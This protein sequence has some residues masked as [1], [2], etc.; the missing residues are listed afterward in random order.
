MPLPDHLELLVTDEPTLD[1]WSVGPWRVPDGLCE[2]IGARLDDLV[3]DPRY[4]DLTTDKSSRLKTPAPLVVLDLIVTTEFLLGPS[5][6]RAGSHAFL[7][8]QCY[9]AYYRTGRSSLSTADDWTVGDG[10]FLPLNWLA[11][12]PDLD[13][14]VEL[15]RMS[16]DVLEGVEPL[17][18]RRNA[19]IRLFDDPP[20]LAGL[21]K[22]ARAEA[23]IAR[24]D[25]ETLAALPELAGP[26]GY[27]EWVWSGLRP[28]HEHLVE[29]APHEDSADDLLVRLLAHAGLDDVPPEISAV[30]GEE[31]YRDLLD[32]FAAQRAGHDRDKWVDATGAWLCRTLGAGEAE[33][34]RRW[35]DLVARF[36]GAVNGLPGNALFPNRGPLPTRTVMRQL[37]RLYAPRRSVV[38]PVMSTLRPTTS[39]TAAPDE[40]EQPE[41]EPTFGLV[42]QPD[43]VAALRKMST[44]A[45]DVR[46]LLVGPDG[47]G[48]RD[49]ARQVAELLT[50]RRI[51]GDPLWQAGDHYADKGASSATT[52]VLDAVGDCAGKRVLIIDGLDVLAR[53]D[54]C[55]AAVLEELHR[56]IDVRDDLH[57]VALCEPGGDEAVREVNPA[58]ALRFT[59]VPTH[60]FDADGFA[61]LFRRALRKR[62][63]HAD[64]DALAAAGELLA[65]T[66]PVR[67]LRNARLAPHLAGLVLETVRERTGPGD[68]LAV[69]RADLPESLVDAEK[70]ADPMAELN[71]LTGL[72]A[73][74]QEIELVAA[75]VRAGRLRH[76]AGLPATA[77]PALHMVFTGN[78]GTGKTVVARLVAR[79]FKDLGVLSSGHLVEASRARLVAPYVGQTAPKTRGVVQSALGGVLFIDE[80]YSLTQ[81]ASGNDY[82][83]EAVAELLN[84]LEDHRDDL[85]VI[86]AGYETE[87]QRFLGANPGLASRFP[88]MVR[89]PDYTGAE[90]VEIFTAQASAAGM[91]PSEAA[92]GKVAELLRRAPRV[93]SFGNARVMRNLC[94][95]ATA[96]Q[97]RR[98]TALDTPSADDLTALLPEDIPDVLSGTTRV[99]P[100]T[101]PVAELD[102]LIGLA[103]VKAEV[104]RL[105]AEARAAELRRDAGAKPAAPTRHMVFTG[106]PGTAKTTV[107]RLV[108]AIY[109]KLGLL[110]SGHLVEASRVDL[111]GPYL[112]QTAPRVRAVVERALGGVLFVDEAYALAG[113]AYGQE[114][115]A[116]LIQLMEEYR[117][118]LVVIAA[119]YERE[120]RRFLT[121]NPGLESRFP[122]RVAFPDYTDTELVAIFRHLATAEGFTLAPDV[123]DRLRALLRTSPRGPSF[124]NG[125][126]MRNLL[127]AAIAAQGER[128]TTGDR[129]DDT[130]ITTLRA[131]DLHAVTPE[132]PP[133]RNVGLYL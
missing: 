95:R 74:K 115:I 130:E 48:K 91:E 84:A 64:E 113:D 23:F 63:A 8:R 101:D 108:A 105:V 60:P 109:A 6:I 11:D 72:A 98:V 99:Q 1:L 114:A 94:E 83:A 73:V 123:P 88:T 15:G 69:T 33:A 58:L 36:I 61:E 34:C 124:G 26:T 86:V 37:R 41:Q 120:M 5:A 25:D 47:T 52:K 22:T 35:L 82:G 97:A 125:R 110:S 55:G 77:A 12:A 53:N 131:A 56:A 40:A 14:A 128:I 93:R 45:G 117:G 30:L 79:I 96:L 107:A 104:H 4:A 85:V 111:V 68:E 51:T 133:S 75:R 80:A 81:S 126:L 116:T 17:E 3:A 16:L 59:T 24:A 28:L 100:V 21:T 89:F 71:A 127:D 43:V 129:P 46:L 90:L 13:L 92:L 29:A 10:E 65:R 106:N 87:M 78:P 122:K 132:T 50:D 103:E 31:G 38:N 54:D 67:N 39:T 19:L 102:A 2:E 70:S 66:P 118:D 112:G 119:G 57:I 7:Q 27:L 62:G 42:G 20:N 76:D 44:A 121:A 9:G 32:R 18:E 49:A